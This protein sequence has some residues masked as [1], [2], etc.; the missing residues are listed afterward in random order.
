MAA[1]VG[2]KAPD[3]TLKQKTADGLKDVSLS[4]YKGKRNV[5]LLFFPFAGTAPCTAEMC[6]VSGGLDEY[7]GLDAEVVAISVDNPFAQETWAKSAGIAIPV[8]SDFN[9][10]VIAAY[11]A[12]YADF[13]GFKGVAKR[14]AFVVDKAGVIRYAAVSDDA[15]VMPDFDAIK[16][17]L[18][19]LS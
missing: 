19:S 4:D 1:N 18:G 2:D 12:H 6:S 8:L 3:F 15:K 14:S 13:L 7:H 9:K 11:G 16:S 17:C 10:T 5:V